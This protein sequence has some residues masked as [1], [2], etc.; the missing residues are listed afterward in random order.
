MRIA[1]QPNALK[2]TEL[3]SDQASTSTQGLD[4]RGSTAPTTLSTDAAAVYVG[5]AK[6]TIPNKMPRA[7][8]PVAPASDARE[9]K[10][11][12]PRADDHPGFL[13]R[14]W[15]HTKDFFAGLI[16]YV[17]L[18]GVRFPVA[19]YKA[20]VYEFDKQGNPVKDADGNPVWSK[21][22]RGSRRTEAEL[23]ALAKG[24]PAYKGIVS[25]CRETKPS[26]DLPATGP[27][28]VT[29]HLDVLDN[30]HPTWEQART[31]VQFMSDPAHQPVFVHCEAGVGRTGQ[32]I[33]AYRI[34]ADGW[35]AQQ[36]IDEASRY[37]TGLLPNQQQFLRDFEK[38]FRA[39]PFPLGH[40]T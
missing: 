36:A 31:A 5:T 25:L 14:V 33:G 6:A 26:V 40:Q 18:L 4:N 15:G 29:E 37:G 10:A 19:D 21:I 22:S 8:E 34:A 30:S 35:T 23:E 24:P 39:N 7:N 12:P 27:K 28:M 13:A 9:L 1:D 2:K 20:E 11:V 3:T 32:I 38:K 16:G 17:E